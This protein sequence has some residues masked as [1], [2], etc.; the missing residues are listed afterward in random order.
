LQE[1]IKNEQFM[2]IS[3]MLGGVG[4]TILGA[5]WS[6]DDVCDACGQGIYRWMNGM[7]GS[8]QKSQEVGQAVL[9]R[10]GDAIVNLDEMERLK[11]EF[12]W[13]AQAYITGA[14]DHIAEVFDRN[15]EIADKLACVASKLTYVEI[16]G[17]LLL[18]PGN[19]HSTSYQD[20]FAPLLEGWVNVQEARNYRGSGALFRKKCEKNLRVHWAPDVQEPRQL[21]L[22]RSF[23]YLLGYETRYASDA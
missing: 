13:D 21:K 9:C 17:I 3:G 4:A 15:E 10:Y 14:P 5:L 1:T 23:W 19:I 22:T 16:K 18:A 20:Q 11:A 12:L 6:M 7:S 8:T 2:T